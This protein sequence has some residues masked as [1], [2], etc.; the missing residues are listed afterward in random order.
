[1]YAYLGFLSVWLCFIY[2]D[3]IQCLSLFLCFFS[4]YALWC[5]ILCLCGG[6]GEAVDSGDTSNQGR[7]K[8]ARKG[9]LNLDSKFEPHSQLNHGE[10]TRR[11]LKV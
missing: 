9:L 3:A 2:C 8:P 10:V 4:C 5:C 7:E 11:G 1:M 6:L